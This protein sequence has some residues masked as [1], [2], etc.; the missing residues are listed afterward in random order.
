M[1][2]PIS[3]MN[4]MDKNVGDHLRMTPSLIAL[5]FYNKSWFSKREKG[6]NTFIVLQQKPSR[7]PFKMLG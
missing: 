4:S 7:N 1:N 5:S 6:I 3:K 2:P